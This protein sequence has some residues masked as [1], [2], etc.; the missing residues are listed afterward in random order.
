[1]LEGLVISVAN[2]VEEKPPEEPAALPVDWQDWSGPQNLSAC[3]LLDSDLGK[4]VSHLPK[5]A[6]GDRALN[7]L[8]KVLIRLLRHLLVENLRIGRKVLSNPLVAGR[9]LLDVPDGEFAESH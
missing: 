4:G 3:H 2:L 6:S 8:A 1:M 7:Q 5:L 9:Q